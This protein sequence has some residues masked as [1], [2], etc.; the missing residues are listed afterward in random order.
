MNHFTFKDYDG[1]KKLFPMKTDSKGEL[2]RY[3]KILLS[4]YK[5]PEVYAFCVRSNWDSLLNIS[6]MTELYNKVTLLVHNITGGGRYGYNCKLM[7][8]FFFSNTYATDNNY[9]LT[10][11]MDC[12][13][14]RLRRLDENKIVKVK[15]GRFMRSVIDS[16][17]IGRIIPE[18]VKLYIC[19]EFARKWETYVSSLNADVTLHTGTDAEDFER[20]Y[21][22][23]NY[24]DGESF[25]SCMED[26]GYEDFYYNC[27][28]A[29]AAWL[30]NSKGEII[31]RCIIYNE[32]H[33]EDSDEI[34]RIAERQYARSD[35]AK[36][37]LVSRLVKAGLI[38]AY[39]KVGAG[40][41]DTFAF[42]YADGSQL[43][44]KMYISN[45]ATYDDHITYQD[46]FKWLNPDTGIAYNY[47]APDAYV[48][49]TNT[50]GT[51]DFG[52]WDNFHEEYCEETFTA[53]HRGSM[54]QWVEYQISTEYSHEY[55]GYD[56]YFYLK[57]DLE[58]CPSCGRYFPSEEGYY[59]EL[60]EETYCSQ[61]C[62][63]DAEDAYHAN[64]GDIMTEEYRTWVE[65]EE[66]IR[67]LLVRSYDGVRRL[68][69]AVTDIDEHDLVHICG[70]YYR[71]YYDSSELDLAA[72][73]DYIAEHE[74][75]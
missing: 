53:Y 31:A 72:M 27:V 5:S 59:S 63:I 16:S 2:Y 40:C 42:E 60:T 50:D 54:G 62:L 47:E 68:T 52:A 20:I 56:G 13:R 51:A 39:K 24:E 23:S 55:A 21:T 14:I 10:I 66:D 1:F 38:D 41:S 11:D 48:T 57:E 35:G 15:P 32:V 26:D 74:V 33:I 12:N 37:Q 17:P 64:N 19:E 61:E 25:G 70:D 9:G 7:D 29:T 75:A 45:S 67:F 73:A 28:D 69:I 44:E 34:L 49:M 36:R 22:S 3:N 6:S 65:S 8:S 18:P 58:Y 43:N 4:W 46:T 30:E 71:H